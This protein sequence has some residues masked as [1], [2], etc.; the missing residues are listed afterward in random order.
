[1]NYLLAQSVDKREIQP[2]QKKNRE[3]NYFATALGKVGFTE[4]LIKNAW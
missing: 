2:H 4:F 1:M 3:I